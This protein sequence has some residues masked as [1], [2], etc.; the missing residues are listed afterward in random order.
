ME[1]TSITQSSVNPLTALLCTF[2]IA[3]G[4]IK[5]ERKNT[6]KQ[7]RNNLCLNFI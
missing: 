6:V 1:K 3:V 7:A 5:S 4:Q 2:L